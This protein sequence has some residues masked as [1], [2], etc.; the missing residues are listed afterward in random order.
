M[1]R[2]FRGAEERRIASNAIGTQREHAEAAARWLA[3]AQDNGENSGFSK[4]YYPI[5]RRWEKSYPETTGYILGSFLKYADVSGDTRYRDRA[6]RAADWLL[7]IQLPC[8]GIQAGT[9]GR[10]DVIPTIFNTGQVVHGWLD[11]WLE[12]HSE[13]YANAAIRACR[14]LVEQQD[15]DGC[16]RR[17]GSPRVTRKSENVYNV[18]V[19]WAMIRAGQ[20]LE[21]P[22]F[23]KAAKKNLEWAAGC[24]TESGWMDKNDLWDCTQPISHTIAYAAEGFFEAGL[25]LDD[26]CL[27][28]LA[29][30]TCHG[31]AGAQRRDG[32]IPGRLDSRFQAAASWVCLTGDAQMLLLWRRVK[33]VMN[34]TRFDDVASRLS[35]A[36]RAKQALQHPDTGVEGG[37]AGSYPV[38][39]DY[40]SFSY[41][42][43]AAKF[44]LDA[45][46][47][48]SYASNEIHDPVRTQRTQ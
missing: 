4:C 14:W 19:A 22:A 47:T 40:Q 45:M 8:G 1:E 27:I 25:L 44:L 48:T 15:D 16:W 2:S 37:L 33:S 42:N 3:T 10:P 39:G 36:L 6:K 43:W 21:I 11:A 18:R 38:S 30:R 28:Q 7:D 9:I 24:E 17:G 41:P 20:I 5:S 35:L 12:W 13:F 46:M 23:V 32:H 29:L 26:E 34:E 31:M